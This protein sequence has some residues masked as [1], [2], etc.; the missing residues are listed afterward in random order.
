MALTLAD[1]KK[2]D[3]CGADLR[4][5][6]IPEDI[7]HC[8]NSGPNGEFLATVEDY[9]DIADQLTNPTTHYSRVIGVEY[10]GGYDGVSEW[11][12]PDCGRREGRFSGKVLEDDEEEAR[13]R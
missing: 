5:G 2:C 6:A 10:Q 1:D 9:R 3:G 4:A 12:C 8:Y 11:A 13:P 7:L